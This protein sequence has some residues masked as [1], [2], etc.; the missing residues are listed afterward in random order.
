MSD[1]LMYWK[2][3]WTDYE[4]DPE[5]LNDEWYTKSEHFFKQVK[6]GDN[7]W[8]VVSGGTDY[9]DEWRLL[10]RIHVRKLKFEGSKYERPYHASGDPTKSSKFDI[11]RQSDL[12]PLLHKLEFASGRRIKT[13]GRLIG[14]SLQAIRPLSD[15]DVV[16]LEDYA[17]GLKRR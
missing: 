14:R 16:R 12:T 6:P 5:V 2:F 3:F 9:A 8:V 10:Q 11:D 13:K 1:C 17:K 7:L 4:G 15:D